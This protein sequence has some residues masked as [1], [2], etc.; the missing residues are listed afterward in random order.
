MACIMTYEELKINLDI[1]DP[2]DV[3]KTVGSVYDDNR[4]FVICNEGD[5]H[6]F[7]NNGEE[8]D[9]NLV[10]V[11][12]SF[13]IQ[14]LVDIAKINNI[15]KIVIPSKVTRI[16]CYAFCYCKN[17]VDVDFSDAKVTRIGYKAFK[18]CKNLVDIALPDSVSLIESNAFQ[19]CSKLKSISIPSKI[20]CIQERV[21]EG[22]DKLS[23]VIFRGKT[24]DEVKAMMN[25]PWGIKDESIIRCV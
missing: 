3:L 17:L 2:I 4:W 10:D 11:I 1:Y 24:L 25:Y 22:C 16:C 14:T 19:N 23:Q 8:D 21:F 9:I 15:T 20:Q 5:C 12:Q 6:L 7:K 13:G 18:L